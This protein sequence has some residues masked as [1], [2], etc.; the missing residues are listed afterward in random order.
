M[1]LGYR[2]GFVGPT[3]PEKSESPTCGNFLFAGREPLT[4]G[5]VSCGNQTYNLVPRFYLGTVF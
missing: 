1:H 4:V 5:L 2:L 3:V